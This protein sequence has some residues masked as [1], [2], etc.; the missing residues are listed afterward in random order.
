MMNLRKMILLLGWLTTALATGLAVTWPNPTGTFSARQ[1]LE[2]VA[3][4]VSLIAAMIWLALSSV[5][6][7]HSGTWSWQKMSPARRQ[8]LLFSISMSSLFTG[9]AIRFISHNH[10]WLQIV[11]FSLVL[12]S[13]IGNCSYLARNRQEGQNCGGH[14][15]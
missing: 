8:R 2:G 9:S 12:V 11:S 10:L 7:R 15:R 4:G 1:F 5:N 13:I 6:L 14:P 3:L